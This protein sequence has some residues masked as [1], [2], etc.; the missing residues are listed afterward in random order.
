M[1]CVQ[2][3]SWPKHLG[4]GQCAQRTDSHVIRSRFWINFLFHKLS[5]ACRER[6]SD[7]LSI[8]TNDS[9][10]RTFGHETNTPPIEPKHLT[11]ISPNS[12]WLIRRANINRVHI[13]K[14]LLCRSVDVTINMRGSDTKGRYRFNCVAV[15][16][17]GQR[18]VGGVVAYDA[19]DSARP[20][21]S[22]HSWSSILNAGNH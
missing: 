9:A 14:Q 15:D 3:T 16:A 19:S 20:R 7:S 18:G 1:D 21:S 2:N 10:V 11:K 8:R 6:L 5:N 4:H 17:R 12:Y 13:R 22:V